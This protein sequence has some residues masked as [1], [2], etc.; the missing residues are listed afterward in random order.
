[1]FASTGTDVNAVSRQDLYPPHD[2][3]HD[4][5]Q[6]QPVTSSEMVDMDDGRPAAPNAAAA[7]AVRQQQPWFP[8]LSAGKRAKQHDHDRNRNSSPH[9]QITAARW[10]EFKVAVTDI[11]SLRRQSY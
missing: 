3:D 6:E 1:M 2:H 5:D 11:T 7:A 4:H 10:E 8:Q 9:T